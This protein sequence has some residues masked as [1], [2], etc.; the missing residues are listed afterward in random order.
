[1]SMGVAVS[2]LIVGMLWG[3]ILT[4]AFMVQPAFDKYEKEMADLKQQ[5]VDSGHAEWKADQLTGKT[6]FTWKGCDCHDRER[7]EVNK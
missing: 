1:M 7:G 6:E 3:W 4:S 2:N 5:A